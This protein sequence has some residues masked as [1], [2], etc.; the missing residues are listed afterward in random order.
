MWKSPIVCGPTEGGRH[1]TL[2]VRCARS[3]TPCRFSAC[4]V[5]ECVPS[6][7]ARSA[8]LVHGVGVSLSNAQN[9]AP[10]A[11]VNEKDANG[12]DVDASVGPE[13]ITTFGGPS[14]RGS[15][16]SGTSAGR[17]YWQPIAVAAI[18]A[19]TNEAATRIATTAIL[20]L[21]ARRLNPWYDEVPASR[22]RRR[23]AR[24]AE[25]APG[26]PG[27]KSSYSRLSRPPEA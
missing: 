25:G 10:S 19:I 4:T 26:H 16:S 6:G 9:G 11:T 1:T 14:G 2:H 20:P 24:A 18:A 27:A 21:P 8:G 23:R 5:K 3:T 22:R 15:A 13:V 17:G 12:P 7:K